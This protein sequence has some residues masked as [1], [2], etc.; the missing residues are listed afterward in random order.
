VIVSLTPMFRRCVSK[1]KVSLV[2]LGLD[3]PHDIS[4]I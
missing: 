3:A 2:E 4:T 1:L